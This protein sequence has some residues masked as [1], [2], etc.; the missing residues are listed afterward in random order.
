M[1][2]KITLVLSVLLGLMMVNSGLNKF[3]MYMPMPEPTVE[4]GAWFM[5][6]GWLLPLIAVVEIVGG[7]LLAIPKTRSLG[8]I[9]LLPVLMGIVLF[10][11][12]IDPNSTGFAVALLAINGWVIFDNK[13]KYLPM[14][15]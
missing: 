8:A 1:K 6:S 5:A 4:S 11:L 14:I 3:F 2:G 7:A 15:G 9:I 12:T 10:H 13:E